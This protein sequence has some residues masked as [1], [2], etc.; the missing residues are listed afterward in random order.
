MAKFHGPRAAD[1]GRIFGTREHDQSD[2]AV[3][4]ELLHNHDGEHYNYY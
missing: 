2:R 1:I 4:A 3:D